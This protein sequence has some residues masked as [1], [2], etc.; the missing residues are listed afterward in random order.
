MS[1]IARSA[2][3]RRASDDLLDR[4]VRVLVLD[5]LAG[6]L[7][8]RRGKSWQYA[9]AFAWPTR[10]APIPTSATPT[11]SSGFFFAPM[12]ALSDG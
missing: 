11:F 4:L 2:S 10:S 9:R 8:G 3:S 12:I 1:A 6:G 7:G 5:D